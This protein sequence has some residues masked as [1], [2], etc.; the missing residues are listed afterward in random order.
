MTVSFIVLFPR[1]ESGNPQSVATL[2]FNLGQVPT[3]T[4]FPLAFLILAILVIALASSHAQQV[5]ASRL[6]QRIIDGLPKYLTSEK[7]TL[8][9]RYLF[10][11]LRVPSLT[12]VAPLAQII[13][14]DSRLPEEEQQASVLRRG[15]STL[16]Y[17]V[18]KLV[19]LVV[20]FVLPGAA[21]VYC[22]GRASRAGLGGP[23]LRGIQVAG[24]LA[25]LALLIATVADIGYGIGA[26]ERLWRQGPGKPHRGRTT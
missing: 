2:P 10:D 7:I 4:F 26:G 6:A 23:P 3:A 16:L 11:I 20:F 12:R 19:T 8:H 25:L 1:I 5:R 24:L 21:L 18:L 14:G 17:V 13:R 9:S 15:L 22:Y